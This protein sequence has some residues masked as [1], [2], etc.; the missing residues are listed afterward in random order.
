MTISVDGSETIGPGG[1]ATGFTVNGTDVTLTDPVPAVN[2]T[3]NPSSVSEAAGATTVTVTATF[4]NSSTYGEGQDGVGDGG[5]QRRQRH[6][7]H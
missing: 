1:T 6:L 7:G 5:R 2:L 4:S 3:V